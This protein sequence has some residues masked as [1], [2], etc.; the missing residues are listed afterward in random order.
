MGVAATLDPDLPLV[1]ERWLCMYERRF[2]CVVDFGGAARPRFGD[3]RRDCENASIWAVKSR[4]RF[5]VS[6]SLCRDARG[7]GEGVRSVRR[8]VEGVI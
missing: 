8:T 4:R 7:V 3:P 5:V 1:G 6:L 2:G